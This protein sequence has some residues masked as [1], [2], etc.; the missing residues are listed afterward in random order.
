MSFLY[1]LHALAITA[2]KQASSKSYFSNAIT[3]YRNV[4]FA[5]PLRIARNACMNAS[6]SRPCEMAKAQREGLAISSREMSLALLVDLSPRVFDLA[7]GPD[8][9]S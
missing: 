3:A 9:A 4:P 8:I 5:Y 6:P 1:E 2:N 7:E